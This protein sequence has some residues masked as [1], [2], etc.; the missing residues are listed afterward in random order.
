MR[1][2]KKNILYYTVEGQNVKNLADA[3]QFHK[4]I[5]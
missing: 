3:E 5:E 4:I 2:R 1:K